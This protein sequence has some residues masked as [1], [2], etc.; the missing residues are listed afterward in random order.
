MSA[1]L[2]AP[3][4]I[5]RTAE[6]YPWG[7]GQVLKLYRAEILREWA[8]REAAVGRMVSQAGLAA[9][10]IDETVEVAGRAGI[11]Y[12]RV[13]GPSM[14]D[15]LARRPWMLW[16][17]ARK[18]AEIHV[19]MHAAQADG[20]PSQ[21][22]DLARAVTYA[23]RLPQPTRE[24]AL[25]ALAAMLDGNVVCHGDYHPDNIIMAARGPIV[26]D[27]MTA[28]R[29]NASAD[30]ART[31]L[32][33]RYGVLPAGV[34]VVKRIMT[35]VIRRAFLS[36]YLRRYRAQRSIDEADI[37][38]WIPILAAARLNERIAVEESMLLRLTEAL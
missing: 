17:Y 18:F 36:A 33:F 1:S 20:L 19:A 37:A 22:A 38:R 16:R 30:V 34:P 32:L 26:I 4:G 21:R 24:R 29:G 2:G 7:E 15:S 5:G 31:V 8:E 9:P 3:I 28:T 6:V 27:W 10:A 25:A 13:N 12:E 14:L 35:G 23:P 11:V